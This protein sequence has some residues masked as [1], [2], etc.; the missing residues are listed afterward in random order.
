[1]TRRTRSW[2]WDNKAKTLAIDGKTERNLGSSDNVVSTVGAATGSPPQV[3]AVGDDTN[4]DL[5]LVAK[6]DGNIEVRNNL[7]ILTNKR[8]VDSAGTNVEFGDDIHMNS[9][10]VTN[11]GTPSASTDAA[12]KGY[13]D[14]YSLLLASGGTIAADLTVTGN[15][16]VSGTTTTI[17]TA[18]LNVADNIVNLNSDFTSGTPT[19]NAGLQVLRGDSSNVQIRW[20]ETSDSWE[21]TR[22]GSTYVK[23]PNQ[24]LDTTDSPTFATVTYT[25]LNDGSNSI[26]ATAAEINVLDGITATVSELNILDGVTATASEL[27]YVDGVTSNIQTQIDNI[28]SSFT[29]SADSGTNDTFTTGGTLTFT[30]GTGIDTTVSDDTITVAIDSTVT[31]LTGT[32]TLTN[33]TLTSPTINAFSGTGNG[34]ITGTLTVSGAVNFDDTTGSTSTSTGALIVDGGVGIA[35]NLYV[36]GTIDMDRLSLTSS[37]TTVSPL[38]LTANSL[39]DGV[40]ALRIDGAQADIF[41]NPSTATHTTVTFAVN[42]DQRLAFGMDSNSDFYITRRTSS[43]WYDDTFVLDRDTGL[44]SLGYGATVAGTLTYSTLNDG[45]TALTSTVAELNILDGVTATATEL[46]YLDGVTGITLG[47][48]NELLVVG[49]DGT[50]IVSDSTLAVDTSN[51][52]LGINQTSPEVTLHM[53]GEGAQSAQIRMEQHN[54]T[55]DAPDIRTRKSRGTAASS[56]KNNAGDFIFRGNFERDNGSAYTTVGQLAVDTNSSNAD[57]FQLTLTVSEDGASIDAANAQ[58]KIDGNDSGAITFNGAYKFPTADGSANQVLQT[59]GSGALS[60]A[61]VNTSAIDNVV[62]D[63]TPQLGGQLDVNGNAIGDGTLELLK[64]SETAS[65][66]NEFTIANAATTNG[67]TLSATGDDTNIDINITPKGTGEVV[68]GAGNLNYG[69]TAITATGTELNLLDGVTG[70]LVTEAGTQTLTNKTLTTPVISSISNT[71]TVTLPTS[72]DTLV[73]RATTDTLTNKTLTSPTVGT[74]LDLSARA[75]VQFYDGDSS[76]YIGL[77]APSSVASNYTFTLPAQDGTSQQVIVTDGAGNWSFANQSG[78]GGASGF[79]SSTLN[80]HPAASDDED[81]ATGPSDDT[82]ETPFEAS[83][84]DAFGVSLG[85]VFDQMEPVGSTTT[86]DLGDSEAYVGA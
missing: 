6:G 60:F 18:T 41:L 38:Q 74:N 11:L 54:D 15:L 43:T 82:A 76:N 70:T 31:T 14:T 5:R 42:D 48:A 2:S 9:N 78:G 66:V 33:K 4:I 7:E 62:E 58:F 23:I 26:T 13:V 47:S 37:Q 79:Q 32:Q 69:G 12:T 64:F 20:N 50:S 28:S 44:L 19:E 73:G 84:T 72:T 45:T 3:S 83:G 21:A 81:L 85:S 27:N 24:A 61:T 52:R 10:K 16:T 34:S 22:D 63:T 39:N 75:P 77:R 17:N 80:T 8:I 30:G 57:R 65:A 36:G 25:T 56:T 55:S 71:G 1:M 49:S 59:D 51:N 86:T 68:I 46:N 67:P 40:G 29:L 53:T 35:E